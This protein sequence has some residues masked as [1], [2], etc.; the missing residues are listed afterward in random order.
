MALE[1]NKL[2]HAVEDLGANAA[3]RLVELEER[4]PAA[5]AVLDA[6]GVADDELHRKVNAALNFRWAGAIPTDEPVNAAFPLP[7]HP[8]R[9]N[10]IAADG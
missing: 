8:A 4:L 9:L 5:Q 2:T 7:P 10:V 6:I 3:Q 1:L